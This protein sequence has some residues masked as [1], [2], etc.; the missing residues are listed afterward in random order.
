[1]SFR[2]NCN[3]MTNEVK[4]CKEDIENAF[5][6]TFPK[7][8]TEN[9]KIKKVIAELNE[10]DLYNISDLLLDWFLEDPQLYQAIQSVTIDY[11]DLNL[12]YTEL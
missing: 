8:S 12:D 11:C 3:R 1:M 9:K 10:D 4:L 6:Y 2:I 5:F 7:D